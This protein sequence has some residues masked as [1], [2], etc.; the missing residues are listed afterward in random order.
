MAMMGYSMPERVAMVRRIFDTYVRQDL[1]FKAIAEMLNDEGIASPKNGT[2]SAH[3][4]PGWSLSTIRSMLMNP[5]YTGAMVW[6]RRAG[7]KFH[8]VAGGRAKERKGVNTRTLIWN[9]EGDWEVIRDSHPAII[10]QRTFDAAKQLR[11][12]RSR[13]GGGVSY[14]SGRAK[15]SPYLLSGLVKCTS[16]GHGYHGQTVN[17]SKLRK[18]GTK[19]KTRYY[20]CGGAVSKGKAVCKKQLIRKDELE[21]EIVGRIGARID[22]FLS[23]GGD[24]LLKGLLV[25]ETKAEYQSPRERRQQLQKRIDGINEDI[26]RLVKSLSPDNKEFVDPKLKELG[27]ERKRLQCELTD[28]KEVQ[29]HDV[30]VNRM[31][32][33]AL[34][35]M[36]NFEEVFEQGTLEERKEFIRLFVEDIQLDAVGKKATV[37]IKKFPAAPSVTTGNSAFQMVAGAGLEPA[38]FGLCLPLQL[39][40]P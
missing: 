26:D 9:D 25:K 38:T 39:S 2:W 37:R 32:D 8:S 13:N 40:L 17:K 14:R 16:C 24:E 28:M 35:C 23:D 18:D 3:T 31:A 1:G 7:G 30:D 21:R 27:K 20:A 4:G 6:N 36:E 19:I 33:E 29:Q 5:N 10:D 12:S 11:E 34:G 15:D 22:E